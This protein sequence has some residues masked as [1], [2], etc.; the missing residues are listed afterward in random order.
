LTPARYK[1]FKK[2]VA[3]YDKQMLSEGEYQ[4]ALYDIGFDRPEA[5][6]IRKGTSMYY[7]FFAPHFS[8]EVELRG[9][10]DRTYKVIDYE[11][12]R[13]LG[14]IHG[15]MARLK[16]SFAKHLMLETNPQ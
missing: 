5:H 16:T 7:A 12:N 8:G 4:G 9:L 6:A 10:E 14:I 3:I 15:P 2:W 13:V 11:S 1:I